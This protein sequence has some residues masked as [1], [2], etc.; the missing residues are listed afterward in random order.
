MAYTVTVYPK[1]FAYASHVLWWIGINIFYSYSSVLFHCD[2]NAVNKI[3]SIKVNYTNQPGT[4]VEVQNTN[5]G[6][7]SYFVHANNVVILVSVV[8]AIIA[9]TFN[10][11]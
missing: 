10:S 11:N 3:G 7:T 5:I 9:G 1:K 4:I 2:E 8:E 6:T